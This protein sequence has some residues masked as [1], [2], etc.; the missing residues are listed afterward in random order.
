MQF[1]FLVPAL[2][3]YRKPL[4]EIHNV[5]S[6]TDH[7]YRNICRFRYRFGTS[8]ENVGI[9]S[10]SVMQFSKISVSVYR[11]RYRLVG[12]AILAIFRYRYRYTGR[13]LGLMLR[14]LRHRHGRGLVRLS[15]ITL[16]FGQ[17]IRDMA[18]FVDYILIFTVFV[19]F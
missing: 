10:V 9:G 14:R 12:M 13:S 2:S 17:Q 7:R 16:S 1:C 19:V 18:L 3:S 5:Y 6:D 4:Q 11:N 15:H 8:S